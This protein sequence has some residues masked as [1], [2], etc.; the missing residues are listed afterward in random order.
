[1]D[2]DKVTVETVARALLTRAAILAAEDLPTETADVPEW[3]GK[4]RI[5]TMTAVARDEWEKRFIGKDDNAAARDAAWTN[6]R[7]SLAARCIVDDDHKRVFADEDVAE[8]GKK[9]SVALERVFEACRR[10][11]ALTKADVQELA[12]NSASGPSDASSTG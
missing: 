3:G 5:R 12:G 10:L 7:A 1:M 4:V 6:I 11:N 2:K 8:L 9:S